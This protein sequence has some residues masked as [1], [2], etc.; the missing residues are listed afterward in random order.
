MGEQKR[1]GRP[2]K[3]EN[4]QERVKSW[5]AK[6]EGRRLDGY[7]NSSASWR[8]KKLAEAWGL[9]IAGV[10]ERLTVEADEKYSPILFLEI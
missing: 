9:S 2:R 6:Q 10:V 4:Q 5:R 3:H 1:P 8:L 7:V